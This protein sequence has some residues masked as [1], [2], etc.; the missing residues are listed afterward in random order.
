MDIFCYMNELQKYFSERIR[1]AIYFMIQFTQISKEKPH[2]AIKI[3]STLVA[4]QIEAG[5]RKDKQQVCTNR[6]LC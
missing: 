3:A 4:T 5:K 2:K 6:I 1:K